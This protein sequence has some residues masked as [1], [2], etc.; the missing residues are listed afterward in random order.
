MVEAIVKTI[1]VLTS[2]IFS[3][4]SLLTDIAER[5]AVRGEMLLLLLFNWPHRMR[6]MI[7]IDMVQRYWPRWLT[8]NMLTGSRVLI[9]AV[10]TSI[11]LLNDA[12]LNSGLIATLFSLG[13]VT[14]I[15]DGSVARA[16]QPIRTAKQAALGSLHDKFADRVLYTPLVWFEYWPKHEFWIQFVLIAATI[17]ALASLAWQLINWLRPEPREVPENFSSKVSAV[18]YIPVV[19]IPLLWPDQW[20]Y[21]FYCSLAAT[22]LGIGSLWKGM[23]A[24]Y[25]MI[26][27]EQSD[28]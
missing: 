17:G 13:L 18:C 22:L 15:L 2:L 6:E 3:I 19:L 4:V 27:E 8:A 1:S 11:L 14:E 16:M 5:I 12:E 26:V 20:R 21:G 28:A 9:G 23:K 24:M 10:I 25:S 7:L